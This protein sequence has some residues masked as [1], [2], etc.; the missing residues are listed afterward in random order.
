MRN[1]H[2]I[3]EFIF[4]SE[5]IPVLKLNFNRE[6]LEEFVFKSGLVADKFGMDYKWN[7]FHN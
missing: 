2:T 5:N 1:C 7:P 6:L 3:H 4:W